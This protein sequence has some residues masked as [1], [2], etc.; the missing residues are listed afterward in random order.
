MGKEGRRAVDKNGR[1]VEH[2][3]S[4][5]PASPCRSVCSLSVSGTVALLVP[6]APCLS[7]FPSLMRGLSWEFALASPYSLADPASAAPALCGRLKRVMCGYGG[8]A[9][10]FRGW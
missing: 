3:V 7:S 1:S 5:I 2:A 8:G 4:P 9:R 10:G 6:E